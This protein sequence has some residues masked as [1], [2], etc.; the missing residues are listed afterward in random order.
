[1]KPQR[2]EVSLDEIL[3]EGVA[4]HDRRRFVDA[5]ER[6]LTRLLG[7]GAPPRDPRGPAIAEPTAAQGPDA[8]GAHVARAITK[9]GAR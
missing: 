5:L 7:Q 4:P 6:E 1:M 3:L 2:I 9:G 8:L